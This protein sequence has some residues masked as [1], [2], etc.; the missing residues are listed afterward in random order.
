[1]ARSFTSAQARQVLEDY[2]ER[3]RDLGQSLSVS[4][5]QRAVI[6]RAVEQYAIQGALAVLETIPVEEINQQR[7]GIRTQLLR[8]YGFSTV[9]D[10]W[11][12]SL[13]QLIAINGVGEVM[14]RRIKARAQELGERAEGTILLRLNAD[15]RDE[16][17]TQVVH[18]VSVYLDSRE[19]LG[20][21]RRLYDRYHEA[22]P[23][24]RALQPGLSGFRWLFTGG[25]GKQ[26]AEEAYQRLTELTQGRTG[27]QTLRALNDLL[28]A[29]GQTGEQAWEAF[30]RQ[31][32]EFTRVLEELCPE[33]LGGGGLYG[34][35]EALARALEAEP[36]HTQG[37][38]CT[39]RRYQEWGVRYILHQR[40]VLL[41]DE[42]GLGKTVQAIA[43]MVSLNY[44]TPG[45]FLVVCPASV[46]QNWRMEL[47]RHSDLRV[48]LI[49]GPLKQDALA[50]WLHTG[51]V[52]VTTYENT[53]MV[54]LDPEQSIT[55]LVVDEAHYIKNPNAK[56]TINVR[57]LCGHADRI[58]LMTGTALENR[59]EEMVG[60]IQILRPDLVPELRELSFLAAAP[61][62][63]ERVAPVYYRRKREEVLT[64]LPEL[65]ESREWCILGPEET[66]AYQRAVLARDYP[67]AR[68]VS[69]NV[70]DLRLSGKARRLKQIVEEAASE[71]RKTL[72]FSFFLETAAA[73]RDLLGQRCLEPINGSV[74][75]GRRQ[76]I[77][78]EFNAA[79]AGTVLICQIQSGGT[80]L[81][82]QAAS[83]VILCEPQFKPS[84]EN[85]AI[86]RAY[87]M[88][89]ARNVLVYRLLCYDT[90]DERI[91]EL[92]EAKQAAFDAFADR[93]EAGQMMLELDQRSFRQIMDEEEE[94]I[95]ARQAETG[96]SLELWEPE[97]GEDPPAGP[98]E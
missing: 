57:R 24:Q 3:L 72:I 81:N 18:A 46:L 66:L 37:L 41:G 67:Q 97:E 39:L 5:D 60:L 50:S 54:L 63:R 98:E 88:G 84:A 83:V 36:I 13:H 40:R 96:N 38:K 17:S 34:L 94:R 16:A 48:T 89:Q 78:D 64:E 32:T 59:V 82:I 93:S 68:R 19:P 43:A 87:R 8:Q 31:P 62:F 91:L 55:M 22:E 76:E 9:A 86:S 25:A 4:E 47:V 71:G 90:V 85:Q 11:R 44:E 45:R 10:L 77:V 42:M 20:R 33:R 56:R 52:A 26:A 27:Q 79:P 7:E 23:E 53:G 2:R 75:P 73:I 1:M 61:Q 21:C 49:Y 70:G 30:L 14:A 51:G 95:R 15:R 65:I 92:L 28:G 12:A 29:E 74:P 6:L 35:P 69:W 58:L 80:G